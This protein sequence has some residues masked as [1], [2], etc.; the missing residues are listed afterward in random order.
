M[1]DALKI[2]QTLPYLDLSQSFINVE[3]AKAMA[4]TLKVNNTLQRLGLFAASIVY[5]GAKALADALKSNRNLHHVD[6]GGNRIA[7]G[8]A[9]AVAVACKA[10]KKCKPTPYCRFTHDRHPMLVESVLIE[11]KRDHCTRHVMDLCL[12]VCDGIAGLYAINCEALA[13]Q[14]VHKKLHLSSEMLPQRTTR[15]TPLAV[16]LIT[17]E[18]VLCLVPLLLLLLLLLQAVAG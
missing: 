18:R 2:N 15:A 12:G 10:N 13:F 14:G 8:G 6:L 11:Y 5:E 1:A 16:R 7:G 3:G 9:H 17:C 4:G